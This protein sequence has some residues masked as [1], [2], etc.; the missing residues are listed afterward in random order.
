MNTKPRI[1]LASLLAPFAV[2]LLPVMMAL[3]TI[4]CDYF[5]FSGGDPTDDAPLRSAGI[6]IFVL[7]PLGYPVLFSVMCALGYGLGYVGQLTRRNLFIICTLVSIPIAITFGGASPYGIRDQLIGVAV[8]FM[9]TMF[10]LILGAC[11][12]WHFA[13]SGYKKTNS[14]MTEWLDC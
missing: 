3:F 6:I 4:A 13:N 1:I 5:D 9:M 2:L 12:W 7:V 10:C 14:K 11:S 8:F